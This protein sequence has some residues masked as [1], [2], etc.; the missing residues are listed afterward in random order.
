MDLRKGCFHEEM[1]TSLTDF[2]MGE[3]VKT[4]YWASFPTESFILINF[5][6]GGKVW[7]YSRKRANALPIQHR[8]FHLFHLLS[9]RSLQIFEDRN[10]TAII[11]LLSGLNN[12]IPHPI[13]A[14]F[15]PSLKFFIM[16]TN[17]LKNNESCE[18][19]SVPTLLNSSDGSERHN[20]FLLGLYLLTHLSQLA[21]L[22]PW[23]VFSVTLPHWSFCFNYTLSVD[24][25]WVLFFAF[26]SL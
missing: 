6:L 19:I 18:Q 20:Y 5:L 24:I 16:T 23:H 10:L 1:A 22:T 14:W 21:S 25:P 8:E 9:I 26:L 7:T 15:L 4:L 13:P 17:E 12:S 2:Q 11:L 3:F